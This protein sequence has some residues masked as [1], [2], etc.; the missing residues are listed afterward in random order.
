MTAPDLIYLCLDLSRD[1]PL[2]DAELQ[3][4]GADPLQRLM[5]DAGVNAPD[6]SRTWRCFADRQDAL[7]HA[8]ASPA[9]V[10]IPLRPGT[11]V[12]LHEIE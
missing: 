9:L 5:T 6:W 8:A 12:A 10:V 4:L 3:R 1:E 11:L 7:N 2:E